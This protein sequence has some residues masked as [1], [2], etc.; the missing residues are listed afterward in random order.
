M[1]KNTIR[2]PWEIVEMTHEQYKKWLKEAIEAAEK[3]G[4]D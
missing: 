2:K 1:Q 4:K 3:N